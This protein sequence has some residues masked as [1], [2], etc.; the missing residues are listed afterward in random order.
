MSNPAVAPSNA[1]NGFKFNETRPAIYTLI[2]LGVMVASYLYTVRTDSIFACQASG[3]HPDSYLSVCEVPHYGDYEHGAFWFDLEPAAEAFATKAD[4]LFVGD[5][6]LQWAFSTAETSKWFSSTSATYYT[7][8]FAAYENSKFAG[9]V[10]NRLKPQAKV[11]VINIGNFF[12]PFEAPI[13]KTV[14]HDDSAKRRYQDKRLLQ[15]VHRPICEY[16]PAICGNKFAIF[17][18][19][20]TG[21]WHS[22]GIAKFKGRERPVSYDNQVGEREINDAV[23]IGRTFLSE[24]SVPSECVFLTIVPTVSTELNTATA[25]AD[26]LEKTLVL[27]EQ[28][29]GLQT[30]DG[31]HLDH[32]S[33]DR[34]SQAF[35]LAA[36]SEIR[37]CLEGQGRI[38]SSTYQSISR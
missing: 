2:V 37:S 35:F 19:R 1:W 34:W 9:A 3:Y 17:R 14:L 22:D 18:S 26:G 38:R 5:S 4:V 33:A 8:G 21:V 31:S 20:Q 28:F 36:G 30:Y 25:I 6:R 11:Y 29:D 13:A 10:L 27:S 7:L 24:L 23:E 16:L 12:Q 15:S 32:A